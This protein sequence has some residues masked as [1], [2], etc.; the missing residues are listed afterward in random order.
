MNSKN[1]LL[2]VMT[3]LTVTIAACG[4]G[5]LVEDNRDASAQKSD[6]G[7]LF[8][9]DAGSNFPDEDAGS[10]IPEEDAGTMAP[11]EDANTMPPDED[12]GMMEPDAA[13]EATASMEV[14]SGGGRVS[15]GGYTFEVQLGHGVGQQKIHGGNYS[16]EG[17]AAIQGN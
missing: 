13:T 1:F 15:G 9:G 6:A 11:E 17:G 10:M 2:S 5:G 4:G 14:G 7:V 3:T 12:A 8:E 16:I